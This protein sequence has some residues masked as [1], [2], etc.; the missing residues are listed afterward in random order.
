M[1]LADALLEH[2]ITVHDGLFATLD[3]AQFDDLPGE[4]EA[5]GLARR[6]LYM[7]RGDRDRERAAIQL[8]PVG[9]AAASPEREAVLA[10]LLDLVGG[11]H[12]V[13]FWQCPAGEDALYKHLRTIN[14]VLIPK[15]TDAY[16]DEAD[17]EAS[18]ADL[19]ADIVPAGITPSP[20]GGAAQFP[21]AES[22]EQT[23][24][25]EAE[26]SDYELVL[27]RHAD[28]NVMAQVLPALDKAQFARLFG[29]AT[30]IAFAPDE[31]WAS[32]AGM[33][34]APRPAGLPASAP[35]PLRLGE[36][37]MERIGD[38]RL[39]ASRRNI[40][41]YLR[42]S[43]PEYTEKL[44]DLE[45]QQ[46]VVNAEKTGDEIGF[47]SEYGH[48]LWAFLTL[49]T[50]G[51]LLYNKDIRTHFATSGRLPDEVVE[52]MIDEVSEADDETWEAWTS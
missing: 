3:G 11:R 37:V 35:G 44:S 41:G 12:A 20:S 14:M 8:V 33:M 25:A 23:D 49:I 30:A 39:A 5:K 4:L 13:V 45:L 26:N 32:N 24:G 2:L 18:G 51:A 28:A 19:A 48:G 17:E 50:D 27:F 21:P 42:E 52:E 15:G 36:D 16:E 47:Q 38:S 43:A 40:E 34:I 10:Q 29:P 46:L 9:G 6:P 31:E 22:S 7:D 1:A